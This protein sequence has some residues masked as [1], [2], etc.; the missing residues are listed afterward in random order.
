MAYSR[1][2]TANSRLVFENARQMVQDAGLDLQ[3]TVLS[4]SFLRTE[5]L[6]STTLTKYPIPLLQNNLQGGVQ[7]NTSQLLA[8]QDS[9]V[10]AE[11]GVFL[12]VPSSATDAT[13]SLLTFA[14]PQ[15]LTTSGAATAANTLYNGY[16][17]GMVNNNNILPAWDVSRCKVINTTQNGVPSYT[18]QTV[19]ELSEVD[20]SSNGFYPVEPNIVIG[21]GKNNVFTLNLPAAISTVQSGGFSRIVVIMRGLLAQNSTAVK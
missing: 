19:L 15:T 21:G 16:I 1:I 13:F 14:D 5:M 8:L 20:F 7:Y 17:N 11:M 12:A 9:F 3:T 2:N 4:Q 6:I 10:V 18:G